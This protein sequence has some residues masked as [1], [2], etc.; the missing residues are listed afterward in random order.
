[1]I[2][3]DDRADLTDLV[4]FRV[5]TVSLQVDA[6]LDPAPAKDKVA[7]AGPLLESK[8]PEQTSKIVEIDV[9]VRHP[10]EYAVGEVLISTHG[11]DCSLARRT[12]PVRAL[13]L[14]PEQ[15]SRA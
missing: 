7:A 15:A 6:L 3:Q 11:G 13:P 2:L 10:A 8:M 14:R 4:G 5:P 1:M 12:P 9:G